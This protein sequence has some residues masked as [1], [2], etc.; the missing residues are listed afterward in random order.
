M[1][2]PRTHTPFFPS[3]SPRCPKLT[4]DQKARGSHLGRGPFKL[5]A[6]GG[7]SVSG[8]GRPSTA[9]L[10]FP[11]LACLS[12]QTLAQLR[13]HPEVPLQV[14]PGSSSHRGW[15]GSA[16]PRDRDVE[17]GVRSSGLWPFAAR[18]PPPPPAS[19]RTSHACLSSPPATRVLLRAGPRR[20]PA[21][22]SAPEAAP[23]ASLGHLP[24]FPRRRRPA[25]AEG[26]ALSPPVSGPGWPWSRRPPPSLRLAPPAGRASSQPP[27]GR[28]VLR[29]LRLPST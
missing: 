14:P 28:R 17:T 5:R 11:A 21:L 29:E 19:R 1:Y 23:G 8:S 27:A 7:Q 24:L 13:P 9:A 2:L 18:S 4:H 16:K 25:V 12:P 22:P 20:R 15:E 6:T 26:P 10:P 3:P